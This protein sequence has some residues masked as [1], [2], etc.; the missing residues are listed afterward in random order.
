MHSHTPAL[1][2]APTQI[3]FASHDPS[4]SP[5]ELESGPQY[6]SIVLCA[7]EE[8]EQA[9]RQA[10]EAM[11]QEGQT[12][13][14]EL[15]R[16]SSFSSSS[17]PSL[18]AASAATPSAAT[19]APSSSGSIS[20]PGSSADGE[21]ARGTFWPADASHQQFYERSWNDSSYCSLVIGP[22]L[23]QLREDPSLARLFDE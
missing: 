22:K 12:Y 19:A 21:A 23:K 4:G 1:T 3:F 8:Q 6:R 18:V 2:H 10:L 15:L 11:R 5:S 17:S 14:T 20:A 13:T 16:C 7:S 9:A